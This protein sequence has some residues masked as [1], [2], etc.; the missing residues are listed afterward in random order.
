[1]NSSDMSADASQID[2]PP[3]PATLGSETTNLSRP[4]APILS[5]AAADGEPTAV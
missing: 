4:I 3:K 1:M 5:A 2:E